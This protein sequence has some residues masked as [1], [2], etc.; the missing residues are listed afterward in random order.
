MR[1]GRCC[2]DLIVTALVF[3]DRQ[4]TRDLPG[5]KRPIGADDLIN[6]SEVCN[7][8][9]IARCRDSIVTGC[10]QRIPSGCFV[11]RCCDVLLGDNRDQLALQ[12]ISDR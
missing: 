3:A 10:C 7:H 6:S 11:I 4:H 12:R 5:F 9:R 1:T 8:N 2:G